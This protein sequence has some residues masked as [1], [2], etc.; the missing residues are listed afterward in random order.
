MAKP[1]ILDSEHEY[2]LWLRYQDG[3]IQSTDV[4]RPHAYGTAQEA[5]NHAMRHPS[6]GG[7]I[8]TKRLK[9]TVE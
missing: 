6:D 1:D 7:W 3:G 5:L 8:L 9:V 4:W 2:I